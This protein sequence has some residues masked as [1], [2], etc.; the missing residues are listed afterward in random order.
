MEGRIRILEKQ[1]TYLDSRGFL[2]F[3]P[4]CQS[5]QH[6][7]TLS[8]AQEIIQT[9]TKVCR[10]EAY[11][12][13]IDLRDLK[14][15]ISVPAGRLLA[16]NTEIR[17]ILLCEAFLINSFSMKLLANFYIRVF[18]PHCPSKVFYQEAEAIM[19]VRQASNVNYG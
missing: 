10:S 9:L 12:V 8:D 19:W 3:R 7:L 1:H 14:G 15:S 11:P 16:G 4:M 17:K 13:I 2:Y 18:Q 5:T 6:E